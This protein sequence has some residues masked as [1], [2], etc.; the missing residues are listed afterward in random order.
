MD[1]KP[2]PVRD[3]LSFFDSF[4]SPKSAKYDPHDPAVPSCSAADGHPRVGRIGS[5][6]VSEGR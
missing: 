1:Q 5:A 3:Y 4:S 6:A 2:L